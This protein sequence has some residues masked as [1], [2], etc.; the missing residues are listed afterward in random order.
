MQS[1]DDVL[2]FVF[3][4]MAIAVSQCYIKYF[5]LTDIVLEERAS[6]RSTDARLFDGRT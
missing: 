4:V 2:Q 6:F 3:D 5:T 1:A